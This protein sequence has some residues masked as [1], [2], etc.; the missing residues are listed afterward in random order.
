MFNPTIVLLNCFVVMNGREI[1]LQFYIL[2]LV[3]PKLGQLVAFS[4]YCK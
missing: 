2:S 3:L 4:N 1:M